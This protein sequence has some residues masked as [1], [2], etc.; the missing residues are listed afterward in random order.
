MEKSNV[1]ISLRHRSQFQG[2]FNNCL[3]SS[4]KENVRPLFVTKIYLTYV[5]VIYF[6]M[7]VLYLP[8]FI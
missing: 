7:S 8:K 5:G 6:N 4:F 1:S 2:L 3:V